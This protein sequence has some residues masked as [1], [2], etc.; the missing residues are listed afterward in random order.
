MIGLI[1]ALLI[2]LALGVILHK[3]IVRE[4]LKVAETVKKILG[5][6]IAAI[7]AADAKKAEVKPEA[8][9]AESEAVHPDGK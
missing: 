6:R 4:D 5:A 3:R 7:K 1:V 2:G 8:E 9:K